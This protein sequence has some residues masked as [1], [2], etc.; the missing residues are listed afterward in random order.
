MKKTAILIT[1]NN[2]FRYKSSF[3][4]LKHKLLIINM[5]DIVLNEI[6]S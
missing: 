5:P 1:L 4:Q 3:R 2:G 6:K